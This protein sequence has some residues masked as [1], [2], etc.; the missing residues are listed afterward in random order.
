MF[1]VIAVYIDVVLRA[2]NI[3]EKFKLGSRVVVINWPIGVNGKFLMSETVEILL[4]LQGTQI[5][6]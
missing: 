5:F 3:F 1:V 6:F 2:W 4:K